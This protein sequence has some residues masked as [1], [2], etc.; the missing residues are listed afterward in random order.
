MDVTEQD[1]GT[2]VSGYGYPEGGSAAADGIVMT[3]R[4]TATFTGSL[5]PWAAGVLRGCS[6][7]FD[8]PVHVAPAPHRRSTRDYLVGT[9]VSGEAVIT[10]PDRRVRAA[11]GS[12]VVYPQNRD[13]TLSF[14]DASEYSIVGVNAGMLGV[15]PAALEGLARRVLAPRDAFSS[16]LAGFFAEAHRQLPVASPQTAQESEDALLALIRA[17]SRAGGGESSEELLDRMLRWIESHLTDEDLGPEAVAH[18]H[19]VSVGHAHRAFRPAGVTISQHILA[20]RLAGIRRDLTASP[21]A[22]VAEIGARWGIYDASRVSRAFRQAYGISPREHR[23]A[24]QTPGRVP[25]AA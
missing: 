23:R 21:R 15:A 6:V 9:L 3:S 7:S 14:T 24:L 11:T 22:S 4:R 18:A 25:T 20:R 8:A 2:I 1:A 12:V 5:A 19:H 16:A 13:V 17:M 10:S